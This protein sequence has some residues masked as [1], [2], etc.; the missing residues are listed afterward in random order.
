MKKMQQGFTLIELMIV[1]A[2]IGILAAIALPA[3][4]DYQAKSK[5]AAGLAEIS[6]GKTAFELKANESE[7]IAEAADIGLAE[8]TGNCAIVAEYDPEG[9]SG[10]ITCT[11]AKAPSQVNG[12]VIT[13]TRDSTTG[14]WTCTNN[15]GEEASAKYAPPT[16]RD[17][18]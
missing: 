6:A 9:D 1:V 13:W 5:F 15:L 2:I 16:C 4:S 8:D 17:Q 18:T 3:Y 12:F 11:I 10:T 14:V 7:A